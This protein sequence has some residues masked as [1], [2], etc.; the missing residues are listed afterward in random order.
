MLDICF[1]CLC[2]QSVYFSERIAWSDKGKGGWLMYCLYTVFKRQLDSDY[3]IDLLRILSDV[4]GKM[5]LE[6][7]AGTPSYPIYDG[8]K[9]TA[10]IYHMLTKNIYL[11]PKHVIK[12]QPITETAL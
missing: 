7:E 12:F 5:A 1:Y 8:T 2:E 3:K 4:S 11:K 9:S 6:L 10:T